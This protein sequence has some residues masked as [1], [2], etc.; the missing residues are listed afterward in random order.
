MEIQVSCA[1]CN[2]TLKIAEEWTEKGRLQ[3]KVEPCE[4]CSEKT[5]QDAFDTQREV[6]H[7]YAGVEQ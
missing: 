2:E 1:A 4:D 7:S 5:R 3:L 6:D